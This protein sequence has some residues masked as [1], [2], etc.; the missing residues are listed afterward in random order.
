M[1]SAP[2][3]LAAV[4]VATGLAAHASAQVVNP[5]DAQR[6]AQESQQDADA[7][8][9]QAA[10]GEPY[11]G[12]H[13]WELPPTVVRGARLPQ[14][15]EEDLIGDYGQPRWTARRLFPSTRVYVRPAGQIEFEHWTRIKVPKE[16][17]STT[18]TSY[19]L[20]LGLPHRFQFD[21]YYVTEQDGSQGDLDVSEQKYELRYAFADWGELWMNP[22]GYVEYVSRGGKSD[23]VE[24]KL[25]LG[26]EVAPGWHFG[27]N[28]VWEHELG[29]SLENEY[30]ITAGLAHTMIDQK[31]SLGAEMKL[32]FLDEHSDR[33]NYAKELE[34]GP[35][36]QYRPVP[37]MHLDVAPLIGIGADSRRAD[38]YIVWGWEF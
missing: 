23:K 30:G 17:R 15:V 37:Q 34:V 35:S 27:T 13:S 33:G 7:S 31:L 20:E 11:D 5:A 14:L 1:N 9:Q 32:A 6:S 26:D 8:T 22:T 21:L 28:L 4:L 10:G 18:E 16:G 25:L 3:L 29:D 2:E 38:I 19:E 36:L 24:L 12:R